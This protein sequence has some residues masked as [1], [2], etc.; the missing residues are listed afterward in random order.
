MNIRPT[1]NTI[2]TA[3]T[4]VYKDLAGKDEQIFFAVMLYFFKIS[5]P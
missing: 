2:Q 4:V 1:Y 5:F 3:N